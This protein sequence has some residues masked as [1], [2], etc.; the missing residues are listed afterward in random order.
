[1][2]DQEAA[3]WLIG[4][5]LLSVRLSFAF[6][7]SPLMTTYRVPAIA[8][9][10][11]VLALACLCT[12]EGASFR[13]YMDNPLAL[14][15]AIGAESLVGMLLGASVHVALASFSVA[16]R[17]LDVQIGLGLGSIF[18]PLTQSSVSA[19]SSALNA[20]GVCA[21]VLAGAHLEYLAMLAESI[22][23]FPIG[24]LPE[25]ADPVRALSAAGHMFR[26]GLSL[27]APVVVALLLTDIA[28]GVVSR[29]AP[30]LNALLL[31]IPIKLVIGLS[32]LSMALPWWE[33]S[34]E[35]IF[36]FGTDLLGARR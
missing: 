31:A 5:F 8:R 19:I 22:S 15:P 34:I 25:L 26:F 21:F 9:L 30:Q 12:P 11:V 20:L 23:Y 16:G 10:I 18:D 1:M 6:G 4:V 2:L 32:I 33:T 3:G 28:V 36:L 13:R 14:L 17:L 27:A 7:L 29:N 35:P 24:S